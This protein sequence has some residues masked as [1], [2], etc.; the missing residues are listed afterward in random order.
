MDN[1]CAFGFCYASM[2]C[3]MLTW[4]TMAMQYVDFVTFRDDASKSGGSPW[5]WLLLTCALTVVE[6]AIF[7]AS[8]TIA[9]ESIPTAGLVVIFVTFVFQL[10]AAA[11]SLGLYTDHACMVNTRIADELNLVCRANEMATVNRAKT[12]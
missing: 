3:T 6:S 4:V 9:Y 1:G 5:L 10:I 11:W 12:E 7:A 8:V 2:V